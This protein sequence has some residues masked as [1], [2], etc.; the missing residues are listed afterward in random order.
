VKRATLGVILILLCASGSADAAFAPPFELA[1]GGQ[2][3]GEAR[4][5]LDA[6]GEATFLWQR[7]RD[8]GQPLGNNE[9]RRQHVDGTL[10]P[11][12]ELTAHLEGAAGELAVDPEGK[13]TFLFAGSRIES[14]QRFKVVQ[15]RTR[16]ADGTIGPVISVEDMG[17]SVG[18]FGEPAVAV[19]PNGGA[20]LMWLFRPTPPQSGTPVTTILRTAQLAPNGDVGAIQEVAKLTS[21]TGEAINQPR[22]ATDAHGDAYFA[23]EHDIPSN[24]AVMEARRRDANGTLGPTHTLSAKER[25]GFGGPKLAVTPDGDAYFAWN[26]L[27]SLSPPK[28]AL[29]ARRLDR[30]GTLGPTKDIALQDSS[31][32]MAPSLAAGGDGAA[33]F[34]WIQDD[35]TA[36]TRRL[37]ADGTLSASQ[38]LAPAGAACNG[39]CSQVTAAA[40]DG[41]GNARFIWSRGDGDPGTAATHNIL[42]TRERTAV[43]LLGPIQEL[44]HTQVFTAQL[45]MN[46]SGAA[47]GVWS[48]LVGFGQTP[49]FGAVDLSHSLAVIITGGPSGNVPDDS[50]TFTFKAANPTLPPGRFECQLDQG[51]F[52]ECSSPQEYDGLEPG[53]HS[54]RVRYNP[55]DGAPGPPALRE[56]GGCPDVRIANA[57]AQGCFTERQ[58]DGKGT[59]VFET[60]KQAWIGGFDVRPKF[61]GKLVLDTKAEEVRSEGQTV[62]VLDGFALLGFDVEDLPVKRSDAEVELGQAGSIEKLLEIPIKGKVR[63]AWARQGKASTLQAEISLDDI[64]KPLGKVIELPDAGGAKGAEA[65]I[66]LTLVNGQG[67]ILDSAGAKIDELNVIPSFFRLPVVLGF[68]RLVFRYERKN[69][70]PFWTAGGLIAVPFHRPD[71]D[72]FEVGGKVFAFDG[73]FAGAGLEVAGINKEIKGTPFFLQRLAGDLVFRP[74][75]G[76]NFEIGTTMGPRLAGKQLFTLDGKLTLGAL[77]A[78]TD[79]TSGFNAFKVEAQLK[80]SPFEGDAPFASADITA[81][82]CGYLGG[83]EAQ[84]VTLKGKVDFLK[85]AIGYESTQT[86]FVSGEGASLEGA[87]ILRIAA[88][89]TIRGKAIV[90]T[91]GI[92]G[93]GTI[94]FQSFVQPQFQAGFGYHWLG[95]PP[96]AF[97]GCDLTPFRATILRKAAASARTVTVAAGL[98]HVAFSASAAGGPPRVKVTGPGGVSVSSPESG[99]PLGTKNALV[100]PAAAENTTYVV[101]MK[102]KPGAW[103][104]ESLDPGVA[105]TKVAV[106][107]GLPKPKVTAKVKGKGAKH[108]L[109]YRV[110]PLAGQSVSFSERGK[111]LD[112]TLG[113]AKPGKGSIKFKPALWTA[114]KRTIVAH[115][116]QNGLPRDELKVARFSVKKLKLKKPK[117]KARRKKTSLA[118]TW[119]RVT[120]A[121][122][123]LV[124]VKAGQTLLTRV[125]IKA[126]K[127]TVPKTPRKGK[128]KASVQALS[129]IVPAGPVARLTVKP[130]R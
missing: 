8:G 101:V 95:P 26:P 2:F 53:K 118:L 49:A 123:Y 88:L 127:L 47:G 98:P 29:E 22:L 73:S 25:V 72:P 85:G 86:G 48:R 21:P 58:K 14:G 60:N 37:A 119:K 129:D 3:V 15:V 10:G 109:A 20:Q 18:A 69:N 121:S 57:V 84:E 114:T 116:V 80:F 102:P 93:C 38:D 112:H 110:R 12:Q 9:T 30:D 17:E 71:D 4:V 124:E 74:D 63:I 5:A 28:L 62:V 81:L 90:S 122:S 66:S 56:W 50:P 87:A 78:P 13:A 1:P 97:S 11:T 7:Q 52:E 104:I 89:T 59:G 111:G 33:H 45:S 126:R 65:K 39:N 51:A 68:R 75:Y 115:V 128:L 94:T 106:A 41:Q 92:A 70:K 42:E 117:V 31:V 76:G 32:F 130:A 61:G 96:T 64:T 16:A 19:M 100:V 113:K 67:L 77:M 40:A 55:D 36:R 105:L 6:A 99:G 108:T 23:W 44:D 54:F 35:S 107:N 34:V 120:G 91:E 24:E 82:T 79:C 43:G 103:K 46:A 83:R 27:V 125:L